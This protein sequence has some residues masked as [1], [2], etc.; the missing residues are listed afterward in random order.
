MAECI[1]TLVLKNSYSANIVS[2]KLE[3]GKRAEQRL[4]VLESFS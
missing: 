1:G 3:A 4:L 2:L